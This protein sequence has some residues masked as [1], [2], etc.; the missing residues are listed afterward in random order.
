MNKIKVLDTHLTNMIAA[1]EVV[2]RPAGIIKELVE[3]S[4]DAN[5]TSIEVRIVEGGMGL[6]EVSDNGDGMSGDDLSQAFE[7]HSTSKINSVL[8]LNAIA[9]FGFRGEA[10]PSIASVSHVE[11]LSND[12]TEGHRIII[13][14]GVKK[15]KERAARNQG[16]TISVS[17]LFLKTPARLKHIK[18][19]HYE[20]SIILDTIQKFAMGNPHIS[21][22]LYNESKISFRSYGRNDIA[23]VF[24]RVYGAQVTQD[25]KLF[26]AENYDFKIDGIM[27]LPQHNRANR[28]SIWLYIN[29]RMI[30]FPKIQ[31]AIVDGYRRHMPTDRYPIVVMNIHVDPQ[32]VDVNVHPSKWEIRLSK[33]NVLVE[34]I[35]DCFS[36]ILDQHMRPQRITFPTQPPVQTDI[37]EDLLGEPLPR[38]EPLIEEPKKVYVPDYLPESLPLSDFKPREIE[39]L[40]VS[41]RIEPLTVLSQMSGC[42]ILAQG[43]Q[44]L[45][46]IDQHAAMERVRYEYY[47]NKMLNQNNP[48]QDFLIPLIIEGRKPIIGRVH[49]INQILKEFQLELEV[50]GDDAFVLRS[51]PLWIEEKIVSEFIHEVLDMFEDERTIREEDLRR[52]VLATL[53]CHSS[54]RFNEYMSMDEMTELVRQ[55]RSC[56]Q[57]FHCPHGRPTFITVE[58]KQLIKEFK[59]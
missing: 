23:D 22:T 45:Y 50:F 43:D 53:A 9:S 46:I 20:T 17:S 8:D 13:D 36:S 37:K 58:H 19:I 33:D 41:E 10:L 12:G 26:N 35:Q 3:N 32:L 15:V 14:N 59:R 42:Y 38:F 5:A 56:D 24:H 28:Y 40:E 2:E 27:A 52:N 57:P 25:T 30:R 55:L 1:G 21:F 47:Q 29:N 48:T 49:E 7:R 54:V 31:K 4:I 51:T 18:N 44:G 6:I 34:L 16:T 39:P 11:A